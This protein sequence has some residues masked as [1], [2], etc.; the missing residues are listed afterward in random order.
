MFVYWLRNKVLATAI[1]GCWAIFTFVY[2][3]LKLTALQIFKENIS[4]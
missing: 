3:P 1:L 4:D 2:K